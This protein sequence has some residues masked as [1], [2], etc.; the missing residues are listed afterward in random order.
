MAPAEDGM[1]PFG[2]QVP[3]RHK[4]EP[5]PQLLLN[6]RF[7]CA[8]GVS[9]ETDRVGVACMDCAGGHVTRHFPI[10]GDGI[11]T[12]LDRID[13]TFPAPLSQTQV[14]RADVLD[15][16]FAIA[17][18]RMKNGRYNP[19]DPLVHWSDVDLAQCVSERFGLPCGPATPPTPRRSAR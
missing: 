9:L 19:P 17:G 10:A 2:P 15:V 5:S 11:G 4:G 18:H 6:P 8:F 13:E 7:G 12:V 14:T 16:G 1:I 3:P